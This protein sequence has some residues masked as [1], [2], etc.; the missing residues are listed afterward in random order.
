MKYPKKLKIAGHNVKLKIKK[1]FQ[2]DK[3]L[4]GD[5][6]NAYNNIRICSVFPKSQQEATLLHE[7]FHHIFVN[8]GEYLDKGI[9]TEKN[10]EALAQAMYQ[11][12]RD[13]NLDFRNNKP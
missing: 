9:H 5:S 12:L 8:L 3:K 11:I 6:F 1:D 4:M 7:I 2:N 13:N 10:V